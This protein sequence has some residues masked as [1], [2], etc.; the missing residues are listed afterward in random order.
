MGLRSLALLYHGPTSG[1]LCT[2]QSK[3][4]GRG[5]SN[6]KQLTLSPLSSVVPVR[7]THVRVFRDRKLVRE[8]PSL[9]RPRDIGEAPSWRRQSQLKL[10]AQVAP[11]CAAICGRR[12]LERAQEFRFKVLVPFNRGKHTP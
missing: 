8:G 3:L 10:Q 5:A 12:H 1:Q 2:G 4:R 9:Q 7:R 11:L 6:L